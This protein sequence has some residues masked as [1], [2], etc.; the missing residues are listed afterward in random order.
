MLDVHP[1]HEAPHSWRDFFIHI[2]TIVIGLII[3]VG[4]EQSVELIHHHHQRQ[5]LEADLHAESLRNLHIALD[6]IAVAERLL[7]SETSQYA[8]LRH[9]D[10]N[11]GPVLIDLTGDKDGGTARPATAAWT[12]AQQNA[13]LALLPHQ[14]AQKYTRVYSVAQTVSVAIDQNNVADQVL[15]AA[16]APAILDPSAL[17]IAARRPRRFDA[18]ALDSE[19][20]RALRNALAARI[21]RLNSFCV[22]NNFLYVSAW[23]ADRGNLSDQDT[24]RILYDAY[25]IYVNHGEAALLAT[26]PL[27]AEAQPVPSPSSGET[28]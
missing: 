24:I 25:S 15:R 8:Q 20:L 19:D 13:T 21:Q 17:S 27:P 22:Y 7:S 6:N 3:A 26:Y 16:R 14:V 11:H 4:L 18:A 28:N 2:I 12:T 5:Q 23:A 1:P 10:R 9:L